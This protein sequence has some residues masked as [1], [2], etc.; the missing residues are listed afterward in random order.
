MSH[1]ALKVTLSFW[2]LALKTSRKSWEGLWSSLVEEAPS[3]DKISAG[4]GELEV[5]ASQIPV[6]CRGVTYLYL[7]A[8]LGRG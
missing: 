1:M 2:S 6:G 5:S 3:C 4:R 7:D 8:V